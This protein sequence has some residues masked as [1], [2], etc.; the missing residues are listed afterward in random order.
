MFSRL[1][2]Q[3]QGRRIELESLPQR[4]PSPKRFKN[5]VGWLFAIEHLFTSMFL[6]G[7]D[8]FHV[9]RVLLETCVKTAV[10]EFGDLQSTW[11]S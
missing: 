10:T 2:K 5:N 1:L 6:L 3:I 11:I 4:H 7:K 8:N 9:D